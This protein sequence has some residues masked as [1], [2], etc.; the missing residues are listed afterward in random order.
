VKNPDGSLAKRVEF[1]NSLV[2]SGA[3]ATGSQAL[4]ALLSGNASL[5][6]TIISNPSY[7]PWLIM[8]LSLNNG[9][10]SPCGDPDLDLF[11]V[12]VAAIGAATAPNSCNILTTSVTPSTNTAPATLTPPANNLS[13]PTYSSSLPSQL[14]ISGTTAPAVAPGTIDTVYTLILLDQV[15]NQAPVT[16]T[17]FPFPFTSVTLPPPG[18]GCGGANQPQCAVS[19]GV[20]QTVSATVTISFS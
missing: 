20:G 7:S 1:E 6:P 5:S 9:D 8:L 16:S 11:E 12:G 19:V 13:F 18:S 15:L 17:P 2:T 4:I 14:I 3:S 10:S